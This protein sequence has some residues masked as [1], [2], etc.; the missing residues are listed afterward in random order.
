M[1]IHEK[2][3]TWNT[4]WISTEF[5]V[6]FLDTIFIKKGYNA[7]KNNWLI[8]RFLI[9]LPFCVIFTVMI[10]KRNEMRKV[11][12]IENTEYEG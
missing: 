5:Y 11:C 10:M 9:L 2:K 1:Q 12:K 8:L 3:H 4:Q 6:S 7:Q